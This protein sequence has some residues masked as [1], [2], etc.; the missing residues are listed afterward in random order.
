MPLWATWWARRRNRGRA[1]LSCVKPAWAPPRRGTAPTGVPICRRWRSLWCAF[2]AL[3]LTWRWRCRVSP[4]MLT[5]TGGF[6]GRS[7]EAARLVGRE[8]P[9]LRTVDPNADA[10]PWQTAGDVAEPAGRIVPL[11]REAAR[12]GV[13]FSMENSGQPLRS[14]GAAGGGGAGAADA[15][16]RAV[17]GALPG[18]RPTSCGGIPTAVRWTSWRICRPITLRLSTLSRRGTGLPL[19]GWTTAIWTAGRCSVS[20]RAKGTPGRP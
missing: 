1:T 19:I 9:Q 12:Q 17:S 18:S 5:R 7:W 20:F 3:P 16:G 10:V 4:P 8:L 15:S 2:P 14:M 13:I 6:T 11:V